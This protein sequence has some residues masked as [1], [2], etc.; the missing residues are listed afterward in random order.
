MLSL[1][2]P[3]LRFGLIWDDPQW[4]Q[5]GA[6]RTFWQFLLPLPKYQFYRP[7][8]LWLNQQ[9]VSTDRV[10]NAPLAHALQ[11]GAHLVA[12]LISV[13]VDQLPIKG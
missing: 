12:V 11:I 1:Y 6:G 4:Y 8:S 7:L 5:Q 9:L 3:A 10:V 2:L 13:P